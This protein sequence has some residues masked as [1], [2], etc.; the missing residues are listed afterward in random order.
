AGRGVGG[1]A[2]VVPAARG[3]HEV[4]GVDEEGALAVVRA[5][6]GGV[7]DAVG[8]AAGLPAERGGDERA[9]GGGGE[10]REV[11]HGGLVGGRPVVV[12]DL[13]VVEED[14]A[15]GGVHADGPDVRPLGFVDLDVPREADVVLDGLVDELR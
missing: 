2:V 11:R 6:D 12:D 7:E 3:G 5:L 10:R 8:R 4:G 14:G 15:G 13:V 9:R 1:D